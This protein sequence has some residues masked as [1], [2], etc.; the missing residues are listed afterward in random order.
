MV[1]TAGYGENRCLE[2]DIAQ[3]SAIINAIRCS[4][5]IRPIVIIDF[6]ALKAYRGEILKDTLRIVQS[7]IINFEECMEKF[8]VYLTKAET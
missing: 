3:Q 8:L 5:S 1:D 2:I 4:K 7:L 6:H